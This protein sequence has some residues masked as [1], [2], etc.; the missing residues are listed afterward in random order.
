MQYPAVVYDLVTEA[1]DRFSKP[2]RQ[3]FRIERNHN[4]APDLIYS[5]EDMDY[6][7]L[8]R[9]DYTHDE[10]L[11][12]TYNLPNMEANYTVEGESSEAEK[13]IFWHNLIQLE[14]Y[15]HAM[16]ELDCADD[17]SARWQPFLADKVFT[18]IEGWRSVDV[19]YD[20]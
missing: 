7:A 12:I 13:F 2:K 11:D 15:T 4:D 8:C 20:C 1:K 10:P 16:G 18:H 14:E 5:F 19:D 17:H 3:E 9:Y 6:N